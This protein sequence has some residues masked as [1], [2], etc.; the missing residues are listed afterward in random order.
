MRI[1][2][3]NAHMKRRINL[4]INA[5][6][7][8]RA[9]A[10]AHQQETSVSRLVEKSLQGLTDKSE[11]PAMRF[12]DEWMGK[13]TLAPRNPADRKREHLWR[14]YGLTGNADSH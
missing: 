13:L 6:L 14:K 11:R 9:K 2:K 7:V 1:L 5:K 10:L 3:D 12:A 8:E 4:T